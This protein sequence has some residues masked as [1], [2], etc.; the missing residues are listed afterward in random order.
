MYPGEAMQAEKTWLSDYISAFINDTAIRVTLHLPCDVFVK[1]TGKK[2][3]EIV[4][5][6]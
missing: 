5:S 6:T 3:D 2:V 1:N 4:K